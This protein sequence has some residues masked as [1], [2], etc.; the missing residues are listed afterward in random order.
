V[1]SFQIPF[2]KAGLQP[3]VEGANGFVHYHPPLHVQNRRTGFYVAFRS[4]TRQKPGADEIA[5]GRG[6]ELS[7]SSRRFSRHR[8]PA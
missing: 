1:R 5:T 2:I 7:L 8:F 6:S 4:N 3:G